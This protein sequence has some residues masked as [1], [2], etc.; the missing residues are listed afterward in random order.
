[1]AILRL[2]HVSKKR[3]AADGTQCSVLEGVSLAVARGRFSV[4][5]GPSGGGKTTLIRLL[6]R[7]EDPSSG[8]IL[9]DGQ[10]VATLDPIPL[11]RRV[12]LVPQ[13][14]FMFA[15]T[16]LQNLQQ[17]FRFAGSRLPLATDEDLLSAL[18][19]S[20]FPPDLLSQSAGTL[21]LGQQQRLS[22]ARCLLLKPQ[23]LLLDEPT[24]ALD[25]PTAHGLADTLR[26][27]SR[28]LGLTILMVTHDL[29]L[30][31]RVADDLF[32]I[33]QGCLVEQGDAQRMFSSP[34]SEQFRRFI[35]ATCPQT[36]GIDDA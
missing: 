10:D 23:L 9:L 14:P 35:G 27:I 22:V 8:R 1:M 24:S 26:G 12:A 15:G 13:R 7:L 20:H 28:N 4:V 17:P 18:A 34:S 32:Y 6:N 29:D 36:G 33:E 21:S 19:A 30:A 2:E 11:R 25:R 16:A 3:V 31:A 5:V